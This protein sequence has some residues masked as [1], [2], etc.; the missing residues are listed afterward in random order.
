M[1][2][3][4]LSSDGAPGSAVADV[5]LHSQPCRYEG[6]SDV[7]GRKGRR[8]RDDEMGL[9]D[10][11]LGEI[12]GYLAAGLVFLT[13]CMKT[14]TSLRIVAI[15]SNL[16]FIVY[17]LTAQLTP[18]L[19]LHGLLLPLNVV[20]LV[21]IN[22]YAR[23]AQNAEAGPSGDATFE[24]LIPHAKERRLK[25]GETLFSKGDHGKSMFVIIEG[26]IR[27]PE[28]GV[29]LGPGALLGEISLFSG[30][31]RRTVGAVAEGPVRLGEITE[32]RVR[33]LYF[34]N[35][36]F[37]YSLIRVITRRL[38]EN[39]RNQGLAGK[40]DAGPAARQAQIERVE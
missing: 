40:K 26:Q 8:S 3:T 21:Q 39:S 7:L 10:V 35:P 15:A 9:T 28:I 23:A 27:L 32:R 6:G 33:E 24:W 25:A 12:V 20:R 30:D 16:C 22:R 14:M 2:R 34:D 19:I 31:G 36:D 11:M 37:A 18:I 4:R 13:F 38:L 17:A 5:D 29:T 1:P